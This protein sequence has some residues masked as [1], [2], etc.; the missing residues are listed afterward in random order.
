MWL[1]HKKKD[2]LKKNP[3]KITN[4]VLILLQ[5][6]AHQGILF[7]RKE[8]VGFFATCAFR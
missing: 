3:I 2:Q 1:S 7:L 6:S 8:V 5:L 4:L